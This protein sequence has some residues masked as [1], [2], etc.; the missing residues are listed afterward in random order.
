MVICCHLTDV[1]KTG[2]GGILRQTKLGGSGHICALYDL[3][4]AG[5]TGQPEIVEVLVVQED[6]DT[7]P[8]SVDS[9]ELVYSM[10]ICV[11]LAV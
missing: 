5:T 4:R 11:P 9:R 6:A 3:P 8:L 1:G 10:C 7:H 2:S